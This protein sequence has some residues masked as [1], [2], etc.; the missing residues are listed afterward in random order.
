MKIKPTIGIVIFLLFASPVFSV[1][2]EV[3]DTTNLIQNI[4]HT[5]R[6]I[7]IESATMAQIAQ[8]AKSLGNEATMILNLCNQLKIAEQ[9]VKNVVALVRGGKYRSIQELNNM[10]FAVQRVGHSVDGIGQ[11][12]K[13]L[14]PDTYKLYKRERQI[15]ELKAEQERLIEKAAANAIN[16]QA[17]ALDDDENNQLT[18]DIENIL[19]RSKTADGIKGSIQLQSQLIGILIQENR[20]LNQIIATG[21]RVRALE[22]AQRMSDEKRKREEHERFMKDWGVEKGPRKVMKDFP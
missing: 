9:N 8:K 22:A 18:E 19:R 12:F 1:V 16:V 14:F 15:Q 7:H 11:T 3:R 5:L 17:I 10:C 20:K 4:E 13:Q 6:T 21:E 2:Q